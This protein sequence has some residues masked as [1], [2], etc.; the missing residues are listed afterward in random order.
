[1]EYGNRAM[2]CALE[3]LQDGRLSIDD[4]G[5]IWRHKAF[6]AGRWVDITPRRAENVGGKGYFRLSL[7][8]D[9]KLCSVM[10]HRVIWT[11]FKGPIPTGLQINHKDLDKTNNRVDNLEVVTADGNIQHSYA[12]GRNKP[13][14]QGG[15]GNWRGKPLVSE[16]QKAAIRAMRSS[17]MGLKQ[18]SEAA[19]VS[20]SHV[21]RICNRKE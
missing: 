1:M 19:G 18:I 21:H 13:W 10:A 14:S 17:G 12:H 3:M 9:G 5:R 4:E 8:I 2:Q 11:H 6:R 20:I 7:Q 15:S 16:E